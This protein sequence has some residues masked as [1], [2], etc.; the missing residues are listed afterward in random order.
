MTQLLTTIAPVREYLTSARKQGL[1]IGCVPTMGAL[2]AGH[3]SLMERARAATDVV[4]V[5]IF[6]NP[7]QFDRKEDF[8]RYA[9]NLAPDLEF[10]QARKV[11]AVFA[12]PV[13]EMYPEPLATFVDAPELARYLCGASRPG[14]FRGVATVVTKL[15]NIVQPDLAFFGEKDAQQLAIIRQDDERPEFPD[16][17]RGGS[18]RPRA[19]RSRPEF[20]KSKADKRRETSRPADLSGIG[21]RPEINRERR[22]KRVHG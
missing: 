10:C 4:V 14:H 2:H 20:Q 11:D 22:T 9:K 16:S 8:E 7:I 3:A 15:F 21:G 6:V 18:Y 12:P 19:R 1:K 5:T 17:D 13:E